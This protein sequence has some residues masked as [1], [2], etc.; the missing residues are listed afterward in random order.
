VFVERVFRFCTTQ[1]LVLQGSKCSSTNQ[2]SISLVTDLSGKQN[3]FPKNLL[4]A[5]NIEEKSQDLSEAISSYVETG[6]LVE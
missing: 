3:N 2:V 1:A 5:G 4:H 6:Y